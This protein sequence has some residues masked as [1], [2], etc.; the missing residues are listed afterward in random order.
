MKADIYKD[1]IIWNAGV[2]FWPKEKK[3][4]GLRGLA[5]DSPSKNMIVQIKE[6]FYK[7]D[8]IKA[9]KFITDHKACKV[10]EK[11]LLPLTIFERLEA[12]A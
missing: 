4:L 12:Y 6:D 3:K 5:L 11:V 8:K 2:E 7:L 9:D 10:E 1:Q